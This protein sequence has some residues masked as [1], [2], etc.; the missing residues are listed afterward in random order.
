MKPKLTAA[1]LTVNITNDKYYLARDCTRFAVLGAVFSWNGNAVSMDSN[2]PGFVWTA[3]D[4]YLK[5]VISGGSIWK[6]NSGTK[7][8][9]QY[10]N[11]TLLTSDKAIYSYSNRIVVTAYD[12]INA[13]AYKR[14]LIAY[15]DNGATLI[16]VFNYDYVWD[17]NPS[18]EISD[19]V[20]KVV[21]F[22]SNGGKKKVQAYSIDYN[23]KQNTSIILPLDSV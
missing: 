3:A 22:G 21:I 7:T 12:V 10:Y 15:A 23:S 19:Q 4:D 9:T 11:K 18:V 13:T 16:E 14:Q 5:Y 6:Y 17:M 8:Y 20:T 2:T 1:G